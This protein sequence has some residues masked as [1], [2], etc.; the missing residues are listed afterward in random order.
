MEDRPFEVEQ[1]ELLKYLPVNCRFWRVREIPTY[2]TDRDVKLSQNSSSLHPV[3]GHSK[4][5]SPLKLS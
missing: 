2:N 4:N 3:Y 1:R 5:I